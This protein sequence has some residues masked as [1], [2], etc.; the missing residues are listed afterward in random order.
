LLHGFKINLIM[1][2]M[3]GMFLTVTGAARSIE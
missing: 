3:I 1:T 2:N